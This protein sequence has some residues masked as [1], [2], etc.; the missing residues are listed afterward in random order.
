[1]FYR[2]QSDLEEGEKLLLSSK[3]TV[4]SLSEQLNASKKEYYNFIH[5][6]MIRTMSLETRLSDL[7]QEIINLK[8]AAAKTN[9]ELA[10]SAMKLS[11]SRTEIASLFKENEILQDR[12]NFNSLIENRLEKVLS[13]FSMKEEKETSQLR[14]EITNLQ[15]VFI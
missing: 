15:E 6:L 11:I 9:H 10:E 14:I 4:A 2:L 5:L 1:M 13:A 8:T 12:G 7:N 3:I